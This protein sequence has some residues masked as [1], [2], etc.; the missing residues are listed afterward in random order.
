MTLAQPYNYFDILVWSAPG[1]GVPGQKA[2]VEFYRN[3]TVALRRSGVSDS[4]S[5][6]DYRDSIPSS[7]V[8]DSIKGFT[9][10]CNGNLIAGKGEVNQGQ[11]YFSD[12][13]YQPCP[14]QLGCQT[15]LIYRAIR[16][17]LSHPGFQRIV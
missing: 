3:G 5:Y 6:G 8:F 4:S 9:Y 16:H 1:V 13:L 2:Y 15:Q 10:D 7:F 14:V 17:G 12:T 11:T